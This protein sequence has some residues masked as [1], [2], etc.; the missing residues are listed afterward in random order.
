MKRCP[1]SLNGDEIR[2]SMLMAWVVFPLPI[3]AFDDSDVHGSFLLISMTELIVRGVRRYSSKATAH[4][5]FS[6]GTA[7]RT[8][9]MAR[10]TEFQQI[11]VRILDAALRAQ[12]LE[13][14]KQSL[15]EVIKARG[16]F[17]IVARSTGLAR[18]SMYG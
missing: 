14:F 1:L 4:R 6:V 17:T 7:R 9:S 15:K 3:T 5:R 10:E 12:E 8:A 16:G 13:I 18:T 11:A 2:L